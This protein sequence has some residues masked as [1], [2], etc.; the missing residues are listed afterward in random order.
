[1]AKKKV[2][3][4]KIE[5]SPQTAA[6]VQKSLQ[7]LYTPSAKR[8]AD[9]MEVERAIH[10]SAQPTPQQ[11]STLYASIV[12]PSNKQPSVDCQTVPMATVPGTHMPIPIPTFATSASFEI[13]ELQQATNSHSKSLTD[14]R[15]ICD[16]LVASQTL[17]NDNM[18]EMNETF[19]Y[20]FDIMA[21]KMD[22]M[23]NTLDNLRHSPSRSG[24]KVHKT[25]LQTSEMILRG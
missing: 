21:S 23:A 9:E 11:Q 6:Y 12:T 2:R 20:Q 22:D 14:L 17:M 18:N 16:A 7:N 13:Q 19:T 3:Y 10:P 24:A 25:H 8:T 4:S 1:L 5:V 15:A